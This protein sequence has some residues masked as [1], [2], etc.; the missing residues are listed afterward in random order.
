MELSFMFYETRS[1]ATNTV[2]PISKTSRLNKNL[3]VSYIRAVFTHDISK[4]RPTFPLRNFISRMV[5]SVFR[6]DDTER[7]RQDS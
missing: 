6:K 4:L 7:E 5:S 3:R 2:I 1:S